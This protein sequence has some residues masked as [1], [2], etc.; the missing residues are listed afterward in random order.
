[1]YNQK[2]KLFL[3]LIVISISLALCSNTAQS[4]ED[5]DSLDKQPSYINE[6]VDNSQLTQNQVDTMRNNGQSWGNI[7]INARL[8]EQIAANNTQQDLTTEQ[9]YQVALNQVLQQ[10]AAG[11]GNGN[12]ANQNNIRLG[13]VVGNGNSTKNQERNRVQQ[14]EQLQLQTQTQVQ[15]QTQTKAKK[16]GLFGRFF[17]LFGFGKKNQKQNSSAQTLTEGNS[18]KEQ[19]RQNTSNNVQTK[20]SS[21]SQ[22]IKTQQRTQT[23]QRNQTQMRTEGNGNTF[24]N[25]G[26]GK[27]QGGGGR[28][29]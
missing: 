22:K 5:Q 14:G 28:G 15:Q 18:N 23:T 24:R 10:R 11:E 4:Q 8:A 29:R 2:N 27:S 25:Q 13:D 9:K 3:I 20:N 17:G 6:L 7:R 16:K 19:T 21:D 12:I 26:S 1:M